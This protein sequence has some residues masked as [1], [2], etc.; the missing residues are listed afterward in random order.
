MNQKHL[1]CCAAASLIIAALSIAGCGAEVQSA[2]DST[3]SGVRPA[4]IEPWGPLLNNSST[5]KVTKLFVSVY[6]STQNSNGRYMYQDSQIASMVSA[7]HSRNMEVWAA[8]G[9]PSW[10]TSH[11]DKFLSFLT[12]P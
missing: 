9:D 3:A 6:Q 8:Y 1:F 12:S 2:S 4:V 11:S 5:S 10:T 7:A